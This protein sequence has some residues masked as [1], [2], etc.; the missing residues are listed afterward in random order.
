MAR[1]K[2]SFFQQYSKWILTTLALVF[3]GVASAAVLT[4]SREHGY[5]PAL[6]ETFTVY[7]TT[8]QAWIEASLPELEPLDLLIMN[9]RALHVKERFNHQTGKLSTWPLSETT[10]ERLERHVSQFDPDNL[11]FPAGDA[12]LVYA[13]W[14]DTEHWTFQPIKVMEDGQRFFYEGREFITRV[15]LGNDTRQ[16]KPTGNV[17]SR[18][19]TTMASQHENRIRLTLYYPELDTRTEIVTT[20][21][22]PFYV[23]DGEGLGDWVEARD[24]TAGT[25]LE[26]CDGSPPA[27]TDGKSSTSRSTPTTSKSNTPTITTSPIL[28]TQTHPPFWCIMTALVVEG[29][30]CRISATAKFLSEKQ[31]NQRRPTESYRRDA[32]KVALG[33]L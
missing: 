22:H 2:Q 18:V 32:R 4:P 23:P 5:N 29:V 27:W 8:D 28:T 30:C 24:L 33:Q 10:K 19:I 9:G 7:R 16:V 13:K 17:Y 25:A 15:N 6:S 21:E 11:N 3:V 26:T 1:R 14:R 31:K 12:E 20:H